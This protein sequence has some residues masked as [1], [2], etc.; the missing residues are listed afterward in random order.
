MQKLRILFALFIALPLL[1]L[2]LEPG[3]AKTNDFSGF[4]WE[5]FEETT[6]FKSKTDEEKDKILKE[7]DDSISDLNREIKIPKKN[8][9]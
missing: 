7:L 6:D 8:E 9:L 1:S 5:L 2:S 3:N 4:Q